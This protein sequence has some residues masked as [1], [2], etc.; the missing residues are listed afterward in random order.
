MITIERQREY[1]ALKM[2][3]LDVLH[4]ITQ[5]I[6]LVQAH[7]EAHISEMEWLKNALEEIAAQTKG[8]EKCREK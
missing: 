2:Q 1:H 5:H 6:I 7:S 8:I 4:E 3:T